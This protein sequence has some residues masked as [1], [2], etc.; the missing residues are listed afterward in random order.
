[1][2]SSDSGFTLVELGIMLAVITVMTSIAVAGVGGYRRFALHDRTVV[3]LGAVASLVTEAVQSDVAFAYEDEGGGG[4][5]L[6]SFEALDDDAEYDAADASE[7][8]GPMTLDDFE[9]RFDALSLSRS[10][11]KLNP[12]GRPYYV[13]LFRRV[14]AISTCV[15]AEFVTPDRACDPAAEVGWVSCGRQEA[16]VTTSTT[17]LPHGYSRLG[18]TY[19]YLYRG[20]SAP[21]VHETRSYE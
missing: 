10:G 12:F 1:M 3:E 18:L 20:K 21:P 4:E 11:S 15:P 9:G 17:V 19:K 13:T 2:S 8:L 6:A 5:S 14:I 16:C 7:V